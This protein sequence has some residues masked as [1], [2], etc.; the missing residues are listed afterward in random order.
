MRFP[1]EIIVI[2][3]FRPLRLRLLEV[4]E[5][6]GEGD[7][8]LP[9]VA[10]HWSVKD[11]A[12]HLLGGDVAILSGKRDGFR[13][14]QGAQDNDELVQLVNRLNAEWILATR[15]ISPSLLCEMLS[16]TGPKVDALFASLDPYQIGGAV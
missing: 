14:S 15:R 12:A 10:P 13:V 7:W 2:D 9:T 3:R 5:Q 8:A 6:L 4:L 1:G 16:F 11:I